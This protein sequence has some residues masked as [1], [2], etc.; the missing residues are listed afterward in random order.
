MMARKVGP[1]LRSAVRHSKEDGQIVMDQRIIPKFQRPQ[2]FPN[3]TGLRK[4]LLV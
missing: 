4:W 3:S 2:R 1:R